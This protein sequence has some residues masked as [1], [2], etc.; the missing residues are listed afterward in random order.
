VLSSSLLGLESFIQMNSM[1]LPVEYRLAFRE[2]GLSI[3]LQAV[4]RL[5]ELVKDKPNLFK[6]RST[7][8][9]CIEMLMQYSQ[10][11]EVIESFWL[12]PTN[13]EVRSWVDHR[14]INMIMLMTSLAPDG[15]LTI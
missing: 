12:E 9:R 8:N 6:E 14:D 10:L 2:L 15:F 1:Q 4:K 11:I 7:L 13:S 5:Y 3:G